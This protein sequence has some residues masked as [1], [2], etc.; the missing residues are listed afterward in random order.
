MAQTTSETWDSRWTSTRRT[1]R[2]EVVDNFFDDYPTVDRFRRQGLQMTDNGGK[3]IQVNLE[4]SG[5]T[6]QSFDKYDVLDKNPVDPFEAA[7]YKRRYYAVPVILSDTENWENQGEAQV[8]NLLK[9]LGDNAMKTIIAAIDADIY[10]AQSGKNMLGFQDIIADD[11]AGTVGG[12][13][14]ATN[15]W[16]ANQYD[17]TATTFTTQTVTNVFDGID[18]WN[19]VL[20]ACEAEGGRIKMLF[21]TRSIARA[22]RV[23]LSSQGYGEINLMAVKG[24]GGPR[25]PTFYSAEVIAANNCPSLHTYFVNPD[26]IKLNVLRQANFKKTPFTSLQSNGQLAQLA[27]VVAGVQMTT[28]NRRRNGVA[29]AITG[30]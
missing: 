1:V 13:N 4:S 9:H 28:N 20:D 17:T 18:K 14:A 8:F 25:L 21:T 7:F 6:A 23:A 19:D 16:W 15:T 2:P 29:T 5:G 27:Y 22:Y 26:A 12:I 24:M 30:S 10:S 3:E 11:G